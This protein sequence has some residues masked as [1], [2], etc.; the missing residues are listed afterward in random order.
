MKKDLGYGAP[1]TYL[2]IITDEE[3]KPA[4]TPDIYIDD[5]IYSEKEMVALFRKVNPYR[6]TREEMDFFPP[7]TRQNAD[8]YFIAFDRVNTLGGS[9]LP[10][11]RAGWK[12][13]DEHKLFLTT[14]IKTIDM[15]RGLGVAKM[16]WAKRDSAIFG[17]NPAIGMASNFS[18]GWLNYIKSQG[19]DVDP[20][21]ESLPESIQDEVINTLRG[22]K[23]RRLISKNIDMAMKK[24]WEILKMAYVYRGPDI[25]NEAQYEAASLEGRMLWH[26]SQ[27]SGYN[28]RLRAI[29]SQYTVELTDTEN[30]IYQEM[31][32]YQDLRN[33]HSRQRQRLKKCIDLGKTECND[34]YSLE[35]EGDDRTKQ[36]YRTTPTGKLDPY[37]ELSLEAYNDL[38]NEQKI[39]YHRGMNTRG[40]DAKFHGRMRHRL[41]NPSRSVQPT[42][43][44]PKYDEGKIHRRDYTKEQ[45]LNMSNDD[46]RRFHNR[47]RQRP[48]VDSSLR[49]WHTR[50]HNRL[51]RNADLPTFYSP[52]HEQ[53]EE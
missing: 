20:P 42:F 23:P 9:P 5:K 51:Y 4:N 15:Y 33:F 48:N 6:K 49:T 50:M 35:L 14:G 32:K 34:Y 11:G 7:L 45:Y 52:E 28:R 43:P 25:R 53:E 3:G 18:S 29:Q 21:V 37:V 38:T 44:S 8:G 36:K 13:L 27:Y 30:P 19:W 41:T 17:T 26:S 46:K 24:A 16:L 10:V 31:K 12:Y 40:V 2:P 22:D 1:G 39:K 47:M